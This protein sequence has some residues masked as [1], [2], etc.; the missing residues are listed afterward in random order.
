MTEKFSVE[1]TLINRSDT[2][3]EK[4]FI[5]KNFPSFLLTDLVHATSYNLELEKR[6][7][8]YVRSTSVRKY[9]VRDVRNYASS[10]FVCTDPALI[11]EAEL[12]RTWLR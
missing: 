1:N 2:T 10:Y 3:D 12:E 7:A 6:S 11:E 9:N 5:P 8:T 4:Y